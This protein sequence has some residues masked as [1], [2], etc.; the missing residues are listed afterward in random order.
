MAF[1]LDEAPAVY[2]KEEA[3]DCVGII[4]KMEQ[5]AAGYTEDGRPMYEF[6]MSIKIVS[7]EE[8]YGK[9]INK[10]KFSK[11]GPLW[12]LAKAIRILKESGGINYETFCSEAI[13]GAFKFD[14]LTNEKNPKYKN[15]VHIRPYEVAF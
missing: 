5:I 7:P 11:P 15:V 1:S 3:K 9:I 12:I 2:L 10:I 13:Q 4:E 14:Y 8:H 6:Q